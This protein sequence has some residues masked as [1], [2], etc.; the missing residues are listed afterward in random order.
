ML[1]QHRDA[2]LQQH[3]ELVYRIARN[4]SH[5]VQSHYDDLVQV[6]SI[7]LLRAI[8]RFDPGR[9]TQFRTY[10]AHLI[11]SEIRHYL[12]DQVA[13]V[14]LPR[15]LQELLPKVRQAEQTL[16]N[17]NDREPEAEELAE[18]L[19][20]SLEKL[21]E[22]RLLEANHA[23]LSLDQE[24]L[25]SVP[26]SHLTVLEQME[27]KRVR[28]FH[29][30]QEDRII[31]QDSM[32]KI[33]DQSRQIIDFAFYKDLTQTEIAKELGISQMQV[34]RRLKKALGELWETLNTRVTPW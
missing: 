16:W 27:D 11:T 26:G 25:G 21:Q 28:S 18:Y 12:R 32:R 23:P 33:K 29:L 13:V 22:V 1:K 2:L 7:G 8:E 14:K 31:L 3:M 17:Q 4:Y 6:G 20:I 5:S 15:D 24:T 30:A 19:D 10:A 34:S 9:R